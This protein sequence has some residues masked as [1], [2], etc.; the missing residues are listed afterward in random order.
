MYKSTTKCNETICKW[1]KNKH[2]AS[3]IID[4]FETYHYATR[5]PAPAMTTS[6]GSGPPME[7][8]LREQRT[9]R[10]SSAEQLC[11][12]LCKSGTHLH[13]SRCNFML[14]SPCGSAGGRLTVLPGA[15]FLRTSYASF[16][17]PRTRPSTISPCSASLCARF[18]PLL[19]SASASPWHCQPCTA[20]CRI[21]G[22]TQS[23][24]SPGRTAG[25]LTPSLCYR[26][27]RF[28]LNAM[29]GCSMECIA[30]S[31]TC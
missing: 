31:T 25:R 5:S 3:K 19:A 29:P 7:G 16:A 6:P 4:T 24:L 26:C 21:G 28:G 17:T 1:C 18:G 8:S 12:G 13:P 9:E 14:G 22:R 10:S 27:A 11:Q 30:R 2:G 20:H 15:V 23:R